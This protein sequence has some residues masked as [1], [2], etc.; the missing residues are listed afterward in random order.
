[1]TFQS[2]VIDFPGLTQDA[3]IGANTGTNVLTPLSILVLPAF[4]VKIPA[5]QS[6]SSVAAAYDL[7][8][9]DL[10]DIIDGVP[11]I[12]ASDSDLTIR[13]VPALAVDTLVADITGSGQINNIATQ[14]SNILGHGL[15]IPSPTNT[16]FTDLTPAQVLDGDYT[17]GLYGIADLVGQQFPWTDPTTTPVDVDLSLSGASWVSFVDTE[18]ADGKDYSQHPHAPRLNARLLHEPTPTA[19][20]ILA[21][22][23][24]TDIN[25]TINHTRFGSYLPSTTVTLNADP[26]TA[27]QVYAEQPYHYTFQST[28]H[29]QAA[30]QPDLPGTPPNS[31]GAPGEPSLWPFPSSLQQIADSG[32]G[33]PFELCSLSL[34]AAPGA[35]GT[36]LSS[37]CWG[38]LL[39]IE[40]NRVAKPSDPSD[41]ATQDSPNVLGG[42][43]LDNLYLVGG[44]TPQGSNRLYDLWTLLA[45]GTETAN[46]SILYPPNATGAAPSGYAS[47]NPTPAKTVLLKTNLSTTTRD[48]GAR[49]LADFIEVEDD[50]PPPE[51][52]YSAAIDDATDFLTFLWEASVVS[53]GGFYLTYDADG[54]GLP[55]FIF[56]DNGRGTIQILCLL[57]SQ[58][59]ASTSG[60]TLLSVN[61]VAVAADNIDA[62]AVQLFAQQTGSGVPLNRAATL[63]PG[64]VGFDFD[65]IDPTPPIGIDPTP[66]QLSGMLYGLFGYRVNA[67]T[68][69]KASNE[70]VP[71]GP[72][73]K[74]GSTTEVNYSQIIDAARLATSSGFIAQNNPWLPAGATDPYAGI[75]STSAVSFS[76]SAHDIFGNRAIVTDPPSG[77]P[78]PDRYTDPILAINKWPGTTWS[79]LLTGAIPTVRVEIDGA[80]QA[81]N[82]LPGPAVTSAQALS[83]ASAQSLSFKQ[84]YFQLGRP[85]VEISIG[86]TLATGQLTDVSAP[87]LGYLGGGY[88][89]TSQLAGLDITTQSVGASETLQST[90]SDFSVAPSDLLANNIDEPSTW[91]FAGTVSLPTY[92]R[93]KKNETL[94]AFAARMG[95]TANQLLSQWNNSAAALIPAATDIIIPAATTSRVTG[96]TIAD[97]AATAGCTS[98]DI[99]RANQ[100]VGDLITDELTLTV[101]GVIVTTETSTFA[102]LVDQYTQAGVTTSVEEIG[103]TNKIVEGFFDNIRGTTGIAI[104]RKILT[105]G[106]TI[107][108]A[109]TTFFSGNLDNFISANGNLP[110]LLTENMQ[111]QIIASTDTPPVGE[112]LRRYI[113]RQPGLTLAAFAANNLAS[114]LKEGTMLIMPALIDV[115]NLAATPYAIGANKTLSAIATLFGT[116]PQSLGTQDQNIIGIFVPDQTV[117]VAGSGT[118]QTASDDSIAT[119]QNNF[120]GTSKPSLSALISAISNQTGLM[121]PGANLICPAPLASA[122]GSSAALSLNALATSF[123][124][125]NQA[126]TLAKCNAALDG[127]LKTGVTYQVNNVDY[128]VGNH[129]TLANCF[130]LVRGDHSA[131]DYDGFLTGLLDQDIV[132]PTAKV[133]LP[134]PGI[135][136]SAALPATLSLT[137]AITELAATVTVIRPDDEVS[138][139]FTGIDGVA[140][141]SAAIPPKAA[142]VPATLEVF[143]DALNAAYGGTLQLATGP[144]NLPGSGTGKQR[145]YVVRFEPPHTGTGAIDNAIRKVALANTPSYLALP[146]LANA[147]V[148]RTAAIRDYQSASNP[149]FSTTTTSTMFQAVDVQAWVT[150]FLSTLDL[151]LSPD[152]AAAGFFATQANGLSVA[153]ENLVTAKKNLAAKIAAQLMPI[154]TDD[155]PIDLTIAQTA[156]AEQLLVN[157]SE[158]YDTDAVIQLPATIEATFGSTGADTGGHKLTGKTNVA[159]VE[160]STTTT[161]TRLQTQFHISTQAVLEL[162]AATP[163]IL[164]TGTTLS[165][166]SEHWTIAAHDSLNEGISALQTTPEIFATTF[167]DQTPLFRDNV[168]VTIDSYTMDV[169]FGGTLETMADALSCGL[170]YLALANKDLP[171]LLT[172][173][174]YINGTAVTITPATSSLSALAADQSLPL[175][176][177]TSQLAEQAIL[178]TDASVAIARWVPEH[179]LTTGKINLDEAS[180]ALTMFLTMKNQAAFR[181][182]FLNVGFDLGAL[183]YKIEAAPY[184]DGYSRSDWLHFVEPLDAKA[185]PGGAVLQTQIGQME[186]PIPLRAYPDTPRLVRQGA[187]ATYADGDIDPADPVAAQLRKAKAWTYSAAFEV[188][189]AAQDSLSLTLGFN[190][191]S[192]VALMA[193]G[194]ITDPFEA[195]AEYAT[196][197]AAIKSDLATLI[198]PNNGADQDTTTP[199]QSAMLAL[200]DLATDIADNWGFVEDGPQG[201]ALPDDLT[202]GESYEI[203]FQR[204]TRPGAQGIQ[205]MDAIVLIRG[206]DTS[207]WGPGTLIPSLGYI[208]AAGNITPL[209]SP[210][211]PVGS[212]PQDLFYTFSEDVP[213]SD[214][215][216]Y[217]ISYDNL[218]VVEYQNARTTV[219]ISRNQNLVPGK[220]T[221]T[222]F[223]FKTPDVHFTSIAVPYIIRRTPVIFA[224]GT[225]GE[226]AGNLTTLFTDI[227]GTPP[228]SAALYE[229]MI[230]RYGYRL[231]AATG[232]IDGELQPDDIV[233]QSPI[234][235]RPLFTYANSVPNET[236]S[237]VDDWFD[238]HQP[239]SGKT[240]ILSFNLQLFSKMITNLQQPLIAFDQLYYRLTDDTH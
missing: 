233:S 188:A 181:R 215:R 134:P 166:G 135:A 194:V 152:Y 15:R 4:A 57:Q 223:V 207:T 99:A 202:L 28:L 18:I 59:G 179:S 81:A 144:R 165:I 97:Y 176:N 216:A 190:F 104:D 155:V 73:P 100:L 107:A 68:G 177:L 162:L 167:A 36:S 35:D 174:A 168:N 153:F 27:M 240:A 45:A 116:D 140:S 209:I 122:A 98:G 94:N 114:A 210:E 85:N 74:S 220:I 118:A 72:A 132:D 157:L 5:G 199:G 172:G 87:L 56:D 103:E 138:T 131:L 19:G 105:T 71:L 196:N 32:D 221:S 163:N 22:A 38:I 86:I 33:H 61:N 171:E 76:F 217:V 154:T 31:S 231:A 6:L 193:F 175:D 133:I 111:L 49:V 13:D 39:P 84:A 124:T 106:S 54:A 234:F 58:S 25:L 173:T 204:R 95:L 226:L 164:A 63:R 222:P 119:L 128:Q 101:N 52:K 184:V 160:I 16:V 21:V 203:I 3:L 10:V 236:A 80:F 200:A 113:N 145:Q 238:T 126:L 53:E 102:T 75:S 121:L 109:V 178:T 123:L 224:S 150:D 41:T 12:F 2:L 91:I 148:S 158:G 43:W 151:A 137:N 180:T 11:A 110:G 34:E 130:A 90:A 23:E 20:T 189:L 161:L 48:P 211:I 227:L 112:S 195:L 201:G 136:I 187:A 169:P 69:Y 60:G 79:Y 47:D 40:I 147:L 115:S 225:R 205:L 127:F 44:A 212:V 46:I 82:V 29:W 120:S 237:A 235:Y 42:T 170:Q 67:A 206:A 108:D 62:S 185:A 14:V 213:A 149:P 117:T 156:L 186:V 125:A 192:N 1:M 83:T 214:K 77:I 183:E 30:N 88:V 17:G 129:G 230:G 182:L 78:A 232:S 191:H 218:D 65:R 24:T 143:A 66:A 141:A 89:F 219:S 70:A 51:P 96:A 37:Y 142:G 50:P 26:P 197:A 146:P 228:T 159:S 92:G 239:A 8:M 93:V 64:T 139:D 198:A 208:N 55:D 7:G 9:P 229:S